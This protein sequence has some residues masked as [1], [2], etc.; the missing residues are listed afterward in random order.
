VAAAGREA[1]RTA[2]D[3]LHLLEL[4]DLVRWT[5]ERLRLG[6]GPA[7]APGYGP[8]WTL[9]ARGEVLHEAR[10]LDSRF[11][12][13]VAEQAKAGGVAIVRGTPRE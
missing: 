2:A 12:E 3:P 11:L 10:R 4:L 7:P 5:L 9:V 13:R 6:T 8:P 1:H